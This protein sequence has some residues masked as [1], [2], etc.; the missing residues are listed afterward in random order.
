MIPVVLVYADSNVFNAVVVVYAVKSTVIFLLVAVPVTTAAPP[1]VNVVIP[2][3]A[4]AIKSNTF[5]NVLLLS[6]KYKL[7]HV[8]SSRIP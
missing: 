4:F 7:S 2:E 3:P 8:R 1:P 5:C 6:N